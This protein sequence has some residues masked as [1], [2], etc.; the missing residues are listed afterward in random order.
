MCLILLLNLDISFYPI[1]VQYQNH[2]T[3]QQLPKFVNLLDYLYRK[4]QFYNSYQESICR[5][6]K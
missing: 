5:L 4:Q 3:Y 1:R 2:H 6:L